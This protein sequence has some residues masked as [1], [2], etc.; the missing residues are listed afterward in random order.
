MALALLICAAALA[1]T[2]TPDPPPVPQPPPPPSEPSAPPPPEPPPTS[3]AH[4]PREHARVHREHA[5]ERQLVQQELEPFHPSTAESGPMV[6][7]PQAGLVNTRQVIS[8]ISADTG[9]IAH[10]DGPRPVVIALAIVLVL[11][12]GV[13]LLVFLQY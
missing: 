4:H 3:A 5:K 9:S 7:V 8:A 12:S 10:T 2:P 13:L 6:L 1:Q 11:M